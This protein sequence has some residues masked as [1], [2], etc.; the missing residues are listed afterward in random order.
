MNVE[1][2]VS[3]DIIGEIARVHDATHILHGYAKAEG[4]EREIQDIEYQL[5]ILI[6]EVNESRLDQALELKAK[7]INHFKDRIQNRLTI[8]IEEEVRG[9]IDDLD[10]LARE[11]IESKAA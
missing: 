10:R 5:G 8:D 11:N 7:I 9:M 3:G 2:E 6:S 1:S 4:S